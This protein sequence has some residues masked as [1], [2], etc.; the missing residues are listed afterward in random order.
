MLHLI[1][2]VSD[3]LYTS[4]QHQNICVLELLNDLLL[5]NSDSGIQDSTVPRSS[6]VVAIIPASPHY[7]LSPLGF[8]HTPCTA[9]KVS[10]LG[11]KVVPSAANANMD[12]WREPI[13]GMI[14]HGI[15][16]T[17]PGILVDLKIDLP[18]CAITM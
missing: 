18:S 13:H 4:S 8:L 12:R 9:A 3:K 17:S 5:E 1:G 7:R 10:F 16:S 11:M 6:A 15:V 14:W 2:T